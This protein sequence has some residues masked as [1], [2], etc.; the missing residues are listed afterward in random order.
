MILIKYTEYGRLEKHIKGN[1][2]TTFAVGRST[3]YT[4]ERKIYEDLRHNSKDDYIKS[5][6]QNGFEIVGCL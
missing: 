1:I 2:V 4:T 6:L 3:T 5:L